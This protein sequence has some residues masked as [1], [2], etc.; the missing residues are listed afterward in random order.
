MPEPAALEASPPSQTSNQAFFRLPD[1]G[2]RSI[3]SIGMR[4]GCAWPI[5][6]ISVL[7][8]DVTGVAVVRHSEPI[9]KYEKNLRHAGI[10]SIATEGE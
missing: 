7:G 3:R 1:A 8:D 5:T 2:F 6:P 10:R 4:I 9:G